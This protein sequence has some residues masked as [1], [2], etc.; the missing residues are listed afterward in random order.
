MDME[1]LDKEYDR[2]E[3]LVYESWKSSPERL[4][5][6]PEEF[7]KSFSPF[8]SERETPSPPHDKLW[9]QDSPPDNESS[10]PRTD[11][12]RE[13]ERPTGG[14]TEE[15]P[16]TGAKTEER[17]EEADQGREEHHPTGG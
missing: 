13:E 15:R 5:S 6:S 1:E 14:Q 17:P 16:Q 9:I 8:S 7:Q 10:S 12:G 11:R 3:D 2:H 4:S